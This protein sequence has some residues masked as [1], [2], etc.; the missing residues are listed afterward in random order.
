MSSVVKVKIR[1][2]YNLVITQYLARKLHDLLYKFS[3]E[4]PFEVCQISSEMKKRIM[5]LMDNIIRL[6]MD[7]TVYL[8]I[9]TYKDVT[10]NLGI[11]IEIAKK[12]CLFTILAE[13]DKFFNSFPEI[14]HLVSTE[15]EITDN[16]ISKCQ[17]LIVLLYTRLCGK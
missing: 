5:K 2:T 1:K 3:E 7:E 13:E 16:N 10:K 11:I 15:L 4:N 6:G 12:I 17:S 9:N 8:I 14:V